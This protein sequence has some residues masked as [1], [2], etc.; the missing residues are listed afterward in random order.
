MVEG[1]GKYL[2]PKGGP[3][4]IKIPLPIG[5]LKPSGGLQMVTELVMHLLDINEDLHIS[6]LCKF[7][8]T[9]RG[10]QKHIFQAVGYPKNIL[11]DTV[12]KVQGLT[13]DICIYFI[14]N[15]SYHRSLDCRLFNVA[16]S[17]SK[18]HTIIIADKS[19]L[20][21]NKF[22]HEVNF[23]LR[24]LNEDFSFEFKNGKE[25]KLLG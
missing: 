21:R 12:E 1:P 22:D 10:L 4:L 6:V 19:I 3:T 23:F 15:T 11:V 13:T 18:R 17:R 16:T 25:I 24:K 7:T 5:D 8:E 20:I 9:T 2:H 14:P